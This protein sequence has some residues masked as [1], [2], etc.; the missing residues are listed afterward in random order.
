MM[1]PPIAPVLPDADVAERRAELFRETLTERAERVALG[2]VWPLRTRERLLGLPA[3]GGTW[4]K[5]LVKPAAGLPDPRAALANPD[6]LAG[7]VSDFSPD[8]VLEA[9]RR[10]LYPWAHVGPLKWWSPAERCVLKFADHYMSKRLRRQ[11]RQGEYTVTFDRD[12]ESVI[13][14]CTGRREGKWH[15]TWITPKIMHAFAALYDAGYVHSFEV[16]NRNGELAG[17]GYGISTGR[18][19]STESQFSREPNTSKMGFAVLNWH[20]AKW[21]YLLSDG[22]A[23]TPTILDMGFKNIPREEYLGVLAQHGASGGKSGRWETEA[24]L[25]T[26][27]EWNPQVDAKAKEPMKAAS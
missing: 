12:F 22:K 16:W 23:P 11:M 17:G 7:I 18:V 26:V 25:K 4:L 14:A 15:V 19:F 9:Y 20:L 24:D 6:G 13:K 1:S 27:S 2:A 10:G 3:L 5:H 21:G 8:T